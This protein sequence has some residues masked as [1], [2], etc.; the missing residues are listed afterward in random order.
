MRLLHFSFAA[1]ALALLLLWGL[2]LWREMNPGWKRYQREF[3]R[4]EARLFEEQIEQEKAASKRRKV[5]YQLASAEYDSE[6]AWFESP[7]IEREFRRAQEG[8]E[9]ATR[10]WSMA[11]E[12][13]SLANSML[14]QAQDE[15]L[16]AAKEHRAALAGRVRKAQKEVA[17][18]QKALSAA[19]GLRDAA[20]READKFRRRLDRLLEERNEFTRELKRLEEARSGALRRPLAIKQIAV[21]ELGFEDRCT[22][23]HLGISDQR[24]RDAPQPFRSHPDVTEDGQNESGGALLDIHPIEQYGCT[25]CHQ[26]QG[27]AL[28]V[29]DAH[30][31]A[32]HWE[33]PLHDVHTG[34]VEASCRQCHDNVTELAQAPTLN[35]G[36]ARFEELGCYGCHE[37]SGY[38][39]VPK[40]GPDLTRLVSKTTPQWAYRWLRDPRAY[41]STTKMPDFSLTS[42]QAQAVTAYL[43]AKSTAV[44]GEVPPKGRP[45]VGKRLVF[46]LGCLGCHRIGPTGK[47]FAPNLSR[48][49]DKARGDWIVPWLLN[50][51]HYRPDT[52]MP[53]L[54]L[55]R[56]E[57]A[58]LEAY[59]STLRWHEPGP[60]IPRGWQRPDKRRAGER[61]IA[62]M[63]CYG[64][65]R[66]A[67]FEESAKVG[68][69]L[70]SIGDRPLELLDFGYVRIP[71]TR[72]AWLETKIKTPRA[73]RP[74]LK[75][76]EYNLSDKDLAGLV[77]F[78][79]GATKNRSTGA[80][81]H[82]LSERQAALEAGRR[83]A[84]WR[85]CMGCHTMEDPL[86]DISPHGSDVGPNLSVE[87]ER[88]RAQW[89]FNFLQRPTT[90]RPKLPARMPTFGLTAEQ[91]TN[92]VRYFAALSQRPFPFE[93]ETPL[94][95]TPESMKQG[96]RLFQRY[97][98]S[99]CHLV[100]GRETPPLTPI[101]FFM[102]PAPLQRLAPD[103]GLAREEMRPDWLMAWLRDPQSFLRHTSMPYL[104]I[105]EREAAAIRDYLLASPSARQALR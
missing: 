25:T 85:N 92:L 22:T 18:A 2:W 96:E 16:K 29:K 44:S 73:F 75:M 50:P 11:Q 94:T 97:N 9:K 56:A 33:R 23:C 38:K 79:L 72:R 70:D 58:D 74:G 49:A 82:A 1:S 95:P 102:D 43:F 104:R 7:R 60:E 76:P 8:L 52:R 45:E 65:H 78:L 35:H 89:L 31:R 26:G 41:S 46:G 6:K 69:E 40:M 36:K 66:I 27:W 103:L 61:I 42:D 68:A 34:H 37:A 15:Y 5:A 63:G 47:D 105:D 10:R 90:L 30:G 14:T 101:R 86:G 19:E 24:F 100:D 28:E 54:R 55:S 53:N 12:R 71:R 77:T 88:A 59:L 48:V 21:P 80:Y 17:A 67:G 98:C 13:A 84:R 20:R 51:Q 57:A 64:C 62:D 3:N 91:S 32:K 93:V 83:L 87:G 99:T 39:N 4:L 81:S